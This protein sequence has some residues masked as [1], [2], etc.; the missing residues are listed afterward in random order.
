MDPRRFDTLA[1]SLAGPKTRRGFLGG[2]AALGAG[3]LSG[4]VTTAQV[5]QMQCGNQV[6]A[7]NP[8]GCAPGCVCCVYSNG[9]SR[10]RPPGTC[11]GGTESSRPRR[12]QRR[13]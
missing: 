2:L 3:L 9:N 13:P 8:G 7:S 10:C 4:R 5:T 12:H 11:S 6:C 1:R